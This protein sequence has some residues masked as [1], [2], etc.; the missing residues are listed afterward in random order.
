MK[1]KMSKLKWAVK[2]TALKSNESTRLVNC[3]LTEKGIKMAKDA[4]PKL[5]EQFPNIK[6]IV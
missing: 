5:I 6:R 1:K 4:G 3:K 2:F